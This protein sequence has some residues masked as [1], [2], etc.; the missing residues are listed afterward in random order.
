MR[1]KEGTELVTKPPRK[2]SQ[3]N[4]LH[5]RG[6]FSCY[7]DEKGRNK[8]REEGVF[9]I[10]K[11]LQ[12]GTEK[13]SE[14]PG[15]IKILQKFFNQVGFQLN[16]KQIERITT[17]LFQELKPYTCG[18]HEIRP[19]IEQHLK[20]LMQKPSEQLHHSSAV[21]SIKAPALHHY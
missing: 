1:N 12:S 4:L 9:N 8:L 5:I 17:E 16:D 19:A 21:Q 20:E 3:T 11:T 18:L 13:Y 6:E 7:L 14:D 15:T 2:L 10:I